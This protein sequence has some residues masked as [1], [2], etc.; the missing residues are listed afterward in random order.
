MRETVTG[1]L[2]ELSSSFVRGLF[3]YIDVRVMMSAYYEDLVNR[4]RRVVCKTW[5]A[6]TL[7]GH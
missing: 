1:E 4:A 3:L 5:F 7:Y 2:W 6:L